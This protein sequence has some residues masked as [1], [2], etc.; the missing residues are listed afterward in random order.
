MVKAKEFWNY[1][2]MDLEYRFFAGVVCP[3]LV[4]LYKKMSSDFMHY[5]P[6]ANESIA[7]GLVS[8][9]YLSGFKGGLLMDGQFLSDVQRLLNFNLNYKIPLLIIG[10]GEDNLDINIPTIN[11]KKLSD[12]KKADKIYESKLSPVIINIKEGLI[13]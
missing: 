7:L 6:A 12:I 2:C 3:G 10:Y 1:L 8:G 5:I 9:A 11:V 13:S 4:P